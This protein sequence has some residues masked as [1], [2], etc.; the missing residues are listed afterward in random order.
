[1]TALTVGM[2]TYNDFDGVYFTLQSLRMYHDMRDVELL[3]IDNYGCEHTRSLVEG[4]SAGRYLRRTDVQ[5]T[6]APRDLVFR[7]AAGRMVLCCDSHVLFPPGVLSRLQEFSAANPDCDD[8]LQGPMLYDDLQAISTH[9]DPVW[10]DEF[11]GTWATDPRG[12]D[13]NGEPF[14]IPMQGLGVFACRK[15]AWLGFNPR[16][17]G[18]GGEEG[19]IHEKFRQAGR[20]TLCLPWLRWMH[21]FGRPAGVPYTLTVDD[22]FRNYMIGHVELGLEL[23]V[24]IGVFTAHL[25]QERIVALAAEAIW[26]VGIDELSAPAAPHDRVSDPQ[27]V[28]AAAS[29]QS[30]TAVSTA[31]DGGR[32]AVVCFVDDKPHLIQQAFALR[33]SWL[34]VASPDT[35]LVMMGPGNVLARFPADVVK[36]T[37]RSVQNDPEWRG[38]QY[39]NSI[40]CMNG[41]G[42]ELLDSYTHVLRTDVDTFITPAWNDFYPTRF[43]FG[44]GGYSNDDD[45]RQRIGDIAAAYRFSHRGVTNV[46]STWYGPPALV[47]RACAISELITKHLLSHDFADGEGQWP[48]WY[49]EVSLL[50][51]G[52]IAVNHCAP[53]AERTGMLDSG[54]TGR[55]PTRR[56]AHIH[57]WHTRERFSKHAFMD[58]KYSL[59]DVRGADLDAVSDYCM[60]MSF[61]SLSD[62][63]PLGGSIGSQS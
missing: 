5:G 1:M 17:R 50:Y 48:G 57:C 36:I 34:H 62:F 43:M 9:L 54:S 35:D 24:P 11:W 45:V 44:N 22:K 27:P 32:R 21:R 19:Y 31:N 15:S 20:R 49:R 46:G 60:V 16:F 63:P 61:R 39:I 26:G 42:A 4:W 28:A 29:P 58:G 7:E 55:E 25:S 51:A 37:Q 13:P 12:L 52:E 38:Y 8:L 18:F 2:A 33:H 47:R 59:D 23:S 41:D 10:R 30:L 56:S 3:V 14:E 53:D 6:A 40:A